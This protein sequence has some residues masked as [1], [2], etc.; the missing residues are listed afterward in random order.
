MDMLLEILQEIRPGVDYQNET[1]LLDDGLLDSFAL[2]AL[3]AAL[4]R[5]FGILISVGDL[6]PAN[7]NS[8]Q[9]MQSL[10]ERTLRK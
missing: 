3:L 1:A 5:R 8:V 2:S 4:N 10:V 9:A 7:F 6:E